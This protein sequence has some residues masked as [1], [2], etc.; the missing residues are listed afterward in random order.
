MIYNNLNVQPVSTNIPLKLSE[1]SFD[2]TFEESVQMMNYL[3]EA[4]IIT[5]SSGINAR[6][7]SIANRI[8]KL[9]AN[10][11][12]M[13]EDEI[14]EELEDIYED[15]KSIGNIKNYIGDPIAIITIAVDIAT[16]TAAAMTLVSAPYISI[17]LSTLNIIIN[18]IFICN[19]TRSYDK[20]YEILMNLESKAKMENRKAKK[21]NDEQKI[22][23]TEK[24]IEFIEEFKT[25]RRNEYKEASKQE[26]AILVE[27]DKSEIKINN[28][29]QSIDE[30][31]RYLNIA[32][33]KMKILCDATLTM[34]KKC[35]SMSDK[36]KDKILN[37]L[38]DKADEANK[39]LENE[40]M[41][42]VALADSLINRWGKTLTSKYSKYG[43][44]AREKFEKKLT[45]YNNEVIDY[46]N[47]FYDELS[48]LV[49]GE[50]GKGIAEVSKILYDKMRNNASVEAADKANHI[51]ASWY[52]THL[53]YYKFI[54]NEIAWAKSVINSSAIKKTLRYKILSKIVK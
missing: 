41:I 24:V 19:Y 31:A 20:V 17:A 4:F 10:I 3:D 54:L 37:F 52:N 47:N 23:Q 51:I 22:K 43:M 28:F 9:S 53:D 35:N 29:K 34:A 36:N 48:T 46:L 1:V 40:E 50:K 30:I 32:F 42:N 12:S 5:E 15:L 14:K 44:A 13:Q 49:T 33:R 45:E 16:L 26:S 18:M 11:K 21:A 25:K 38:I 27:S 2:V 39:E 7:K 8:K 6:L